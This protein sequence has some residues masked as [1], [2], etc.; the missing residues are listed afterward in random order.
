MTVAS[1]KQKTYN[2]WFRTVS[3]GNRKS[4]PECKCKL[5]PGESIWTW[6]DY[7][8]V[9]WHNVTHFCR[10]CFATKVFSRLYHH[11]QWFRCGLVVCAYREPL[12][13]W[14]HPP[15]GLP[16]MMKKF[17]ALPGDRRDLVVWG[18]PMDPAVLYKMILDE[19][20]SIALSPA[21]PTGEGMSGL[22]PMLP[23]RKEG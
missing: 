20:K 16:D 22:E 9:K 18:R 5:P 19:M 13:D 1:R 21:L 3:L 6:G 8:R 23:V 12:P 11:L 7:Y 14:L 2:A 10:Q 17:A 15:P 4:C